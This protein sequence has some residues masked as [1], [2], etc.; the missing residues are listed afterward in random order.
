[1]LPAAGSPQPAHSRTGDHPRWGAACTECASAKT[2]CLRS[3][4]APGSKC[5]RC[6]RLAKDCAKRSPKAR[7]KRQS[8][9]PRIA[10]VE[11]RLNSLIRQLQS[12][13]N[14]SPVTDNSVPDPRTIAA[15]RGRIDPTS[16]TTSPPF[17]DNCGAQTE[18]LAA[19]LEDFPHRGP[20]LIPQTY[21][22]H[23][24]IRCI[25]RPA[26]GKAAPGPLDSDDALLRIYREELMPTYPFVI[27]SKRMTASALQATRPFLMA[28]IRMVASF[29][30]LRSMQGQMYQLMAYISDHMLIQSE[31]SLDLLSGI[32]V[33]LS[34]HNYHC[35]FHSQLQN[36]TSLAMTLA[37]ELGLK[38]PPSWQERTRLMVVNLGVVKERT[39]E[40]RRLLLAVWHLSSCVSVGFQQLD[41]MIFSPYVQQCLR[42]LEQAGELDSDAYLVQLVKMQ[43]LS[44]RIAYLNGCYEVDMGSEN[45]AKAP[46]S[47]YIFALQA[48]L[49]ELQRNMPRSLRDHKLIIMQMNTVRLR[50]HEPP[51]VDAT[52]LTSLSKS[53]TTSSPLSP[54]SS[55]LDAFY[56]SHA[57]LKQWFDNFLA[58]PVSSYY[59]VPLPVSINM[60]YAIIVLSRW[61]K[62]SGPGPIPDLPP[63]PQPRDPS[64]SYNNPA[65][66]PP[67]PAR[68]TLNDSPSSEGADHLAAAMAMLRIKL[69]TQP[70]LRLDVNGVMGA[71][72][73]RLEQAGAALAAR[74]AGGADPE[75]RERNIWVLKAT[76]LRIAQFK[77]QKWAKAVAEEG[78]DDGCEDDDGSDDDDYAMGVGSEKGIEMPDQEGYTTG[79]T[80]G[81]TVDV[82]MSMTGQLYEGMDPFPWTEGWGD[83]GFTFDSNGTFT[84]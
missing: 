42:E 6:Q 52:L 48:E 7:K 56:R 71:L 8:K 12:S 61:A 27:I 4:P 74:G 36:L 35:F 40:E 70:G 13:S 76:K 9:P 3:N 51:P 63:T 26:P 57:A 82:G 80:G 41:P 16:T 49:D 55:P 58:F 2:K 78:H 38:R 54:A 84:Q 50:L 22:C 34:W 20:T 17:Q 81:Q 67:T 53:F 47:G 64:G 23:G 31:R 59:C 21:N 29:R 79:V 73:D 15:P 5:D 45:I 72:C 10:Q 65:H 62:L 66:D 44:Q 69:A 37:A 19:N 83:W 24:P 1:M 28:C 25:C 14:E 18:P 30:S 11:E 68:S 46:T 77:L 39:N 32:V 33:I 60:I 43:H 75:A